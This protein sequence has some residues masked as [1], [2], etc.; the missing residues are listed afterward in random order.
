VFIP[1]VG[2]SL[3]LSHSG[4]Q[5]GS[6]AARWLDAVAAAKNKQ[7]D[8][9]AL[10]KFA[11]AKNKQEAKTKCLRSAPLRNVFSLIPL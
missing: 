4:P 5:S 2:V 8:C 11:P 1:F 10:P 7:Q 9:P 3:L 6:R